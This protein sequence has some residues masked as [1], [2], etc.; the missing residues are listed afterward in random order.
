[1]HRGPV[2]IGFDGSTGSARAVREAAALLAPRTALIVVVWEAGRSLE[3]ATLPEQALE[4]PSDRAD[5]QNA[6]E[7]E[8]EATYHA[9]R[10]AQHG[11]AVARQAQFQADGF[12]VANDATVAE[13]LARV[14]Q[15]QDAQAVVIGA[16]EHHGPGRH[17]LGSTLASLLEKAP[18]PVL[19]CGAARSDTSTADHHC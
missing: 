1:M 3:M 4:L 10:L 14:A 6:F 7:T 19:V 9:E 2:I 15:E 11:A 8:K 5:L 16:R 12:A 13:T 18:C 17:R